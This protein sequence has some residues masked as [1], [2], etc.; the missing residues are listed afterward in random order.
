[1]KLL[2]TGGTGFLG[3]RLL[4]RLSAA[5]HAVTL[6]LRRA[7]ACAPEVDWRVWQPGAAQPPFSAGEGFAGVVHL[8]TCY[9]RAADS[10]AAVFA[11]NLALPAALLA[12]LGAQGGGVFVN[13]DSYYAIDPPPGGAGNRYAVSK[14]CLRDW[15][16]TLAA[17]HE[18]LR[19]VNLRLEHV[20][21]AGD[22]HAKFV[23]WLARELLAGP[24][25]IALS[26]GTQQRDFIYVDDAAAAFACVLA[27][28]GQLPAGASEFGVGR[29][30]AL[31]L[32]RLA[33]CLHRLAGSRSEL[34]FGALAPRAGEIA[35]SVADCGALKQLGWTADIDLEE[36]LRRVLA[37]E[38]AAAGEVD[39]R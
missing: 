34:A 23:N 7:P 39:S 17:A 37:H 16:R 35:H 33:Q 20:Y 11:A 32:H 10:D 38:R 5:G 30:E 19:F 22:D 18:G 14:R 24:P 27:Q 26:A 36:G 29:G 12:A 25:R 9:G 3:R 6:L 21:G 8:A 2:L 31:P 1:M 15:G 28:A 4:P 13:A